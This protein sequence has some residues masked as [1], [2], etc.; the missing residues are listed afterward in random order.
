[1]YGVLPE[2]GK[3]IPVRIPF[4]SI[5]VAAVVDE[6]QDW[7]GAKAQKWVQVGPQAVAVELYRR[8]TGWL[9]LNWSQEMFRLHVGRSAAKLEPLPLLLDLR[10]RLTD[11]RLVRVE[12]VGWDRVVRLEFRSAQEDTWTLM[13]ELMGRNS[14]LILLDEAGKAVAAARWAGAGRS[15]RPLLP[16]H[17]YQPLPGDPK[18]G[19]ERA[20]FGDDLRDYEGA[21]PFFQK[22]VAAAGESALSAGQQRAWQPVQTPSGPYP[23]PLDALGLPSKPITSLCEALD[24]HYRTLESR[25]EFDRL[26]KSLLAQLERVLASRNLAIE[27]LSQA[28]DSATKA[29]GW[30]ELGELILAY[31]GQI[32]TGDSAL[33]AWDY[34]GNPLRVDLDPE[35]TA[36]ENAQRFF[37]RARKAKDGADEVRSQ[38]ARIQEDRDEIFALLTN[39]RHAPDLADLEVSR[40]YALKKRWLF[41]PSAP[42]A[43]EERPFQGHRIRDLLGPHGYRVLYGENSEANDYLTLRVAKPNDWWLH[44]RGNV[45]AHVVVVTNG[46]PDR[47]PPEVL[48]FAARVSVKNSPMKHSSMVPVDVT[49][50][51]YVRRPKGAP[52]GTVFYTH[53]RTLHVDA[54]SDG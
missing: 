39:V 46:Q 35:L 8:T 22:L 40:T 16:G 5:M 14:N 48:R 25:T 51:K 1:M 50:K 47:V 36:L 41:T 9:H 37:D 42:K 21:S 26:Q 13:M 31:Q 2:C 6:L 30:Q 19:L 44:V 49:L 15:I 17:S 32:K 24:H 28:A 12:Q 20:R 3:L 53:E 54:G 38:L 11:T 34:E 23:L 43:K 27:E 7:V 45:S 18:P 52:S 10:R 4:D 33:E 29:R